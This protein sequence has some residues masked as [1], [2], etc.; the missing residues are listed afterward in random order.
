MPKKSDSPAD[1]GE[2]STTPH[3]ISVLAWS[4]LLSERRVRLY[5]R[6]ALLGKAPL[7]TC[8]AGESVKFCLSL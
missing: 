2:N 7:R 4:P 3:A 8:Q 5:G 6:D 1:L